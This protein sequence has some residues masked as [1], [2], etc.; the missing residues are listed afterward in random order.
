MYM[1]LHGG[2]VGLENDVAQNRIIIGPF[3]IHTQKI[4]HA[5][6]NIFRIDPKISMPL[7]K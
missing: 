6:G 3:I 7:A 4:D 1:D 2:W 5:T